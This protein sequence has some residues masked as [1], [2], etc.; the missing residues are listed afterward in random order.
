MSV[1]FA[2]DGRRA[3]SGDQGGAVRLW[4]L[5]SGSLVREVGRHNGW[6]F[7][8]AFSPDG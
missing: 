6:V 2:P 7:N 1:A 8:V 5:D 4:N 3:L